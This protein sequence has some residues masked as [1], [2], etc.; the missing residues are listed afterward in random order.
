MGENVFE[1]CLFITQLVVYKFLPSAITSAVISNFSAAIS[2]TTG[3]SSVTTTFF[4]AQANTTDTITNPIN[5][6]DFFYFNF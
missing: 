1:H 5:T 6:L 2:L 4:G 3:I